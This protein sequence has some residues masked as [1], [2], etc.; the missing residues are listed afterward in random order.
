MISW[1]SDIFEVLE[2]TFGSVSK[3]ECYLLTR[4]WSSA[5]ASSEAESE[6]ESES[7]SGSG[8][9]GESGRRR[10]SRVQL[11]EARGSHTV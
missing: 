2:E 11:K 4:V 8:G 10:H 5:S 3:N 7:S 9:G 1:T 6:S